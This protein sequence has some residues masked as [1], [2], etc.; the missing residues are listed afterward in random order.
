M[1]HPWCPPPRLNGSAR[2]I[3]VALTGGLPE[4]TLASGF[5]DGLRLRHP[6]AEILILAPIHHA[7]A[8][9]N[10]PAPSRVIPI[11][12]G[13]ELRLGLQAWTEPS[14]QHLLSNIHALGCDLALAP[15]PQRS[16]I[17]DLAILATGAPLRVGWR[18]PIPWAEQDA[19]ADG[20]NHFYTHLASV[21]AAPMDGP[22]GYDQ[23]AH[24]LG[25]DAGTHDKAWPEDPKA[26]KTFDQ[27]IATLRPGAGGWLGL[28][29]SPG[30]A[31]GS[32]D[33]GLALHPVLRERFMGL[34]LFGP[35]GLRET[36]TAPHR[37]KEIPSL[38][39]REIREATEL[40]VALSRCR[41][42]VGGAGPWIH[43]C[44]SQRVPFL[45]LSTGNALN[46]FGPRFP[47]GTTIH[48]PS[49]NAHPIGTCGEG[50]AQHEAIPPEAV[51]QALR[52]TLDQP[53]E[54]PRLMVCPQEGVAFHPDLIPGTT[55][56]ERL[57]FAPDTVPVPHPAPSGQG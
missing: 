52:I 24:V 9:Q 35:G 40:L 23:F 56:F 28:W 38:D 31:T 39:L 14:V 33:W 46:R 2:R 37:W 41:A 32:T 44:A 51:T 19:D 4:A 26:R 20:W 7:R 8:I 6:K 11:P 16:C 3:L 34:M 29:C 1:I 48:Q 43:V 30:G 22:E 10:H 5:L 25:L 57:E 12:D 21:G 42:V 13:L 36:L 49:S 18:T 50:S 45:A 53:G 27:V 55:L 17:G 47:F 54:R 15:S